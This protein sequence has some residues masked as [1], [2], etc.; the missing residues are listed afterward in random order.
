MNM[1]YVRNGMWYGS[2]ALFVAS[3]VLVVLTVTKVSGFMTSS[4]LITKAVTSAKAKNGHDEETVKNLLAKGREVADQLK[5]KSMF[6]NPPPKPKPP[7][8]LGIIG[9]SAIINGKYYKAG[10]KVGAAEIISVGTKEVVIKWEDN[11]M[12]LIPFAV[13]NASPASRKPSSSGKSVKKPES[14]SKDPTKVKVEVTASFGPRPGG[15]PGGPGGRG[16]FMGMSSEER[17]R[18]IDRYRNMSEEERNRFREERRRQFMGEGGGSRG[19]SYR[20]RGR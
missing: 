9:S 17:Q 2:R 16:G 7:V 19:G 11:E 12:K 14:G 8:C 5:K 18:M 1:N 3:V 4:G 13:N 10:D 6:V 20:G 15:G